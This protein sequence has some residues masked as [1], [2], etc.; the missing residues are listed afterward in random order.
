MNGW[1]SK[2]EWM[3]EYGW[4]WKWLLEVLKRFN[5]NWI[6][7]LRKFIFKNVSLAVQT[8]SPGPQNPELLQH[9]RHVRRC[10]LESST[11]PCIT[12]AWLHNTLDTFNL[13][14]Q[15]SCCYLWITASRHKFAFP[16]LPYVSSPLSSS[17]LITKVTPSCFLSINLHD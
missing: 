14:S 5:Q 12:G 10:T 13:P 2:H 16:P 4:K 3:S 7:A 1:M 17:L 9:S 11:P 8:V 15:T 6:K